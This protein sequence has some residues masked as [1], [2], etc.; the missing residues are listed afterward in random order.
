MLYPMRA[1]SPLPSQRSAKIRLCLRTAQNSDW[2]VEMSAGTELFI[3]QYTRV[4]GLASD[5]PLLEYQP[6]G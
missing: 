5:S 4:P 6:V 3:G 2:D 1:Q